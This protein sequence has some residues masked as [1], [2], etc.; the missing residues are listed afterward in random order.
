MLARLLFGTALGALGLSLLFYHFTPTIWGV[1]PLST[2]DLIVWF[3]ELSE[4]YKVALLS[5]VL[6]V[7]GF[8][9]A[10]HTATINWK[11]QL[12]AQLKSQCAGEIEEFFAIVSGLI[13]DAE[14][15]VNSL[16]TAVNK[17]E[18]CKDQD[19]ARFAVD[20]AIDGAQKFFS[21]RN[22]ISQAQVQVHRLKGRNYTI[23]ST[24]WGLPG[25]L[26]QAIAAL[27]E[28]GTKMWVK[29]PVVD[30]NDPNYIQHFHNW[31]NIEECMAF[32]EASSRYTGPMTS[33]AGSIKGYLLSPIMGFSWPMYFDLITNRKQFTAFVKEFHKTMNKR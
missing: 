10:F 5:S 23:L 28:I 16:I 21:T 19:E 12:K 31:V 22:Q 20:W 1:Q 9:V 2:L 3:S 24:G 15:Y 11:N 14:I 29:V 18:N 13:S 26:D 8:I 7:S 17:L 6:T 25:A 33:L 30:K 32:I 4:G 27:N